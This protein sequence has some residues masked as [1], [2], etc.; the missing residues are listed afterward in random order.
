MPPDLPAIPD[1]PLDHNDK[2]FLDPMK[3]ALEVMSGVRKSGDRKVDAVPS[4]QDL[5]DVGVITAD[6]IPK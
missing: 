1:I 2:R 4:W 5:V 6:Q 3:E